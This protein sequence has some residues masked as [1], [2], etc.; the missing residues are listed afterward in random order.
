MLRGQIRAEVDRLFEILP[1]PMA[2]ELD[3][4]PNWTTERPY[5]D[6]IR[7]GRT[8]LRDISQLSALLSAMVRGVERVCRTTGRRTPMLPGAPG[9]DADLEEW[10]AVVAEVMTALLHEDAVFRGEGFMSRLQQSARHL[11]KRSR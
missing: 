6:R 10:D 4:D 11:F 5:H 9:P 8:A 1:A 7:A 2:L 3:A